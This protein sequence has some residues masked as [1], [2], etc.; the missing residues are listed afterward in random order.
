MLDEHEPGV[1]TRFDPGA[2]RL[3]NDWYE[4]HLDKCTNCTDPQ[5]ESLL[6]KYSSLVASLAL[7]IHISEETSGTPVSASAMTRAAGWC[8]YLE[9]H[10]TRIN[11]LVANPSLRAEQLAEHLQDLPNPF[12]PREVRQKGWTGLVE[13]SDI[14][15]ALQALCATGHLQEVTERKAQGGRPSQKYQ[16]NPSLLA[17]DTRTAAI[18]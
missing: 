17:V 10:A 7:I 8:E 15:E 3:F 16:I 9:S 12:T 2:Q 13:R 4:A 6:G 1:S 14:D 11:G 5:M 18:L